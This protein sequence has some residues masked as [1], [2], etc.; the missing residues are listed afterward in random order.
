MPSTVGCPFCLQEIPAGAA[1]CHHCS[2]DVG[3]L[4]A[5]EAELREARA[6]LE[7]AQAPPGVAGSATPAPAPWS[8]N[9]AVA[10][11]YIVSILSLA[12][13]TGATHRYED[14]LPGVMAALMG[15]AIARKH[16]EPNIWHIALYAFGQPALSLIVLAL[17]LDWQVI[18]NDQVVGS[19]LR[20]AVV[21][22]LWAAGA[23]IVYL[24]IADRGRLRAALRLPSYARSVNV[25]E[26]VAKIGSLILGLA[27]TVGGIAAL[28]IRFLSPS[29]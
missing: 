22:A 5:A 17:A 10:A 18:R 9:M 26:R 3:R 20:L 19:A 25:G 24:A 27:T 4:L 15:I 1:V 14:V 2:R 11:F 6:A 13:N 7:A 23:A 16:A 8:P 12:L 21:L 28:L 29:H